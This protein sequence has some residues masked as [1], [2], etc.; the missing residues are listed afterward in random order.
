M[1]QN[2][3]HINLPVAGERP[4]APGSLSSNPVA[5]ADPA[6]DDHGASSPMVSCRSVTKWYGDALILNDVCLELPARSFTSVI[7]PSGCGKT[8]LLRAIAGLTSIDGGEIR[9]AGQAVTGPSRA[10][11]TV[12]Q[13]FG[14]LPWRSAQGNVEFA[15]R[16]RGMP[17][18]AARERAG[19][20][21]DRVGLANHKK[22]FPRHMSGGMQQRVG[23]ARALAAG[24]KVLLMDEPFASVDAQTRESLHDELLALWEKDK[25]TV[26]FV[27]HGIDEA[28]VLSDQVVVMTTD[29]HRP[30]AAFDID[31]P[32]PR[33]EADLRSWSGYP[34]LRQELS[35][36]L[37]QRG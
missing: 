6:A 23:I 2:P 7:G 5:S 21:L 28:I 10:T 11:A 16:A 37:R 4:A 27:T 12:F 30:V 3:V 31:L 25:H 29:A 32:R 33:R 18:Q 14:L 19:E 17:K 26:L 15:L 9:V 13:Q 22:H 34:P 1:S 8:T 20:F 36:L 35:N 24:P